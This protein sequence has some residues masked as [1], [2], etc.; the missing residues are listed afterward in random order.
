MKVIPTS[1]WMRLSSSCIC[2]RSLRSSAPRGSSSSK[3]ARVIDERAGDGDAL[4]LA[5]GQLGRLALL[6]VGEADELER[7]HDARAQRV[8]LDLAAPQ[9]EGDVLVDGE[10]R[11]ERVALEDRVDVA[12]VRRQRADVLVAEVDVPGVGLLEAA[13]HAQRGGLST[14]GGPEQGEEPAPVNVERDPVDGRG[15]RRNASSGGRGGHRR[16]RRSRLSPAHLYRRAPGRW[17]AP[18]GHWSTGRYGPVYRWA[19]ARRD[20]GPRSP[21]TTSVW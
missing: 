1:V 14:A 13:D 6:D 16:R 18:A 3:H 4:L 5:A 8:A 2:L 19:R 20:D 9:P 10:M 21:C 12:L 7:L 17:H 11:E 15:R